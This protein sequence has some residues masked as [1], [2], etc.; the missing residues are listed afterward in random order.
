[1]C[2]FLLPCLSLFPWT[3]CTIPLHFGSSDFS[4]EKEKY[5]LPSRT[6]RG[7]I[8]TTHFNFLVWFIQQSVHCPKLALQRGLM[9]LSSPSGTASDDHPE[10]L[11]SLF[12]WSFT[13]ARSAMYAVLFN[14]K[15]TINSQ[16]NERAICGKGHVPP[17]PAGRDSA[18]SFWYT[19]A[20]SACGVADRA[21]KWVGVLACLCSTSRG[22]DWSPLDLNVLFPDSRTWWTLRYHLAL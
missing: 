8:L 12:C 9:R 22:S 13:W 15:Q 18:S 5:L 6:L 19:L 3:L 21:S 10:K 16:S 11:R 1:M 20:F 14:T 17:L 2:S 7:A 4:K